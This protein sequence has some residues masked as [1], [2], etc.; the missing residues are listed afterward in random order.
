MSLISLVAGLSE[1]A[2]IKKHLFR[3][4]RELLLAVQSLLHFVDQYVNSAASPSD[5]QQRIRNAIGY[6]QKTIRSVTRQLP[7]DN[8]GGYQAMH[9][10]VVKSILEVIESEIRKHSSGNPPKPSH[11]LSQKSKMKLEALD[12]IR[13]ALLKEMDETGGMQDHDDTL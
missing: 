1:L 10:K 12:A 9:R 5:N 11:S 13:N 8:E 6:A 3:A 4:S 2:P 7:T